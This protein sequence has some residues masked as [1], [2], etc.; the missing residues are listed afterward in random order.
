MRGRSSETKGKVGSQRRH[1]E[2][3]VPAVARI[4]VSDAEGGLGDPYNH[5][6]AALDW[7]GVV[8]PRVE[9]LPCPE[10]PHL[11]EEEQKGRPVSRVATRHDTH[12]HMMMG[13]AG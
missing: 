2:V 12:R 3:V 5:P 1:L 11:Q 8:G 10:A 4:H 9:E 6:L 13:A 7:N